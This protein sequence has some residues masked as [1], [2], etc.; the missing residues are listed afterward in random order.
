ML[1]A[2]HGRTERS[3]SSPASRGFPA[4]VRLRREVPAP[5]AYAVVDVETTG[6]ID[7]GGRDRLARARPARRRRGGARPLREPRATGRPDPA[8]GDRRA[9]DRRRAVAGAPTFAMAAPE[10][11]ALLDGAVFVAHN[12]DFDLPLLAARLRAR[13]H[14]LPAGRRRMHA[15]RLSAAR[16]DGAESPAR[17]DLRSGTGSCSTT[18]TTLA[19]TCSRRSSSSGSCSARASHRRPS[20][21]TTSPT[22]ASGRAATRGPPRSRRSDGCSGWPRGAG[23]SARTGRSTATRSRRSSR[24]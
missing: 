3:R 14:P 1:V 18:R 4:R 17:V 8:G 10:L 6:T 20:S 21:S 15:R 19:A 13:G 23:S 11:L 9:R 22:C 5:A 2:C 16:A 12:A 24:G 7:R